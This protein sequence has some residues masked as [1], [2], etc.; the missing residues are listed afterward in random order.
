MISRRRLV[1]LVILSLG[2]LLLS[3]SILMSERFGNYLGEPLFEDAYW[4]FQ[5]DWNCETRGTGQ[6]NGSLI[7][8][9]TTQGVN[10]LT[11][12]NASSIIIDRF[13]EHSA[14]YTANGYFGSND[15]W[16]S[17]KTGTETI[18]RQDLTI[19]SFIVGRDCQTSF[20][21][22]PAIELVSRSLNAGQFAPYYFGAKMN[23]S[24]IFDDENFQGLKIPVFRLRYS[25]P[26][27]VRIIGLLK[28]DGSPFIVNGSVDYTFNFEKTTGV[29]ISYS[30]KEIGSWSNSSASLTSTVTGKYE[31]KSTSLWTPFAGKLVYLHHP[32]VRWPV[33]V[34]G[35]IEQNYGK[36]AL[37][38]IYASIIV[39][40][41]SILLIKNKHRIR[42]VVKNF[43]P[44]EEGARAYAA[45]LTERQR[46]MEKT[47]KPT[48]DQDLKR[49]RCSEHVTQYMRRILQRLMKSK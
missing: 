9:Q 27:E 38:L 23:C 16:H 28:D 45:E 34:A 33:Y 14:L 47:A 11:K 7:F 26:R 2:A 13:E 29:K 48:V 17:S 41:V 40:P 43:L 18:D 37:F 12:M 49:H 1:I 25:G 46:C 20:T 21:G 30:V 19:V 32:A 39:T 35:K 24:V 44:D 36:N 4:A 10:T 15:S 6:Y 5:F 3:S 42:S 31:V 8:N 22:M